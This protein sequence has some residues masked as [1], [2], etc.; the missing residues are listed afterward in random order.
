VSDPIKPQRLTV[1]LAKLA[2]VVGR[3]A[4]IEGLTAML[5]GRPQ[6]VAV[7]ATVEG[8]GGIGKTELVIQLI[9]SE[10]VQKAFNTTVWFGC[11]WTHSRSYW[12]KLTKE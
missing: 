12:L 6:S 5:T 3:D 7:S 9:R 2:L 1:C 11:G 8:L 10:A 4:E